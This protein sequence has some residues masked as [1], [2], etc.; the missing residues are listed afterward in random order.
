M[1]IFS[2]VHAIPCAYYVAKSHSVLLDHWFCFL[3]LRI[4]YLMC[5]ST[6]APKIVGFPGSR[7][8]WSTLRSDWF[9]S[10]LSWL[11]QCSKL[12]KDTEDVSF[13]NAVLIYNAAILF[14]NCSGLH[15][16]SLPWCCM[17]S[18][19]QSGYVQNVYCLLQSWIDTIFKCL[20]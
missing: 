3:L 7:W 20:H 10:V 5:T 9:F 14:S 1:L 17:Y 12:S 2:T 15:D 13:W 11:I 6:Q 19:W 8:V 18:P 16:K 4:W